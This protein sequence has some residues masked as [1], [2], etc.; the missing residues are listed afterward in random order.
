MGVRHSKEKT[1]QSKSK[2]F[3]FC[4]AI[5]SSLRFWRV[6]L[7]NLYLQNLQRFICYL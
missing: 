4:I 3:V 7:I 5:K 2:F 1:K 6:V